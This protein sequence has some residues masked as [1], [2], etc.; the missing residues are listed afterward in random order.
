MP[1]MGESKRTKK[2][3]TLFYGRIM[4]PIMQPLPSPLALLVESV[5][6]K[7]DNFS[8]NSYTALGFF[9]FGFHRFFFVMPPWYAH[10]NQLYT[11]LWLLFPNFSNYSIEHPS[12][13]CKIDQHQ[14]IRHLH[15]HATQRNASPN[16][17]VF[18]SRPWFRYQDGGLNI[19][20]HDD[21]G[22]Y[23]APDTRHL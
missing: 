18:F 17:L 23:I 14:Q 13:C 11:K 19:A 8:F 7:I 2:T 22:R 3:T 16:Q 10:S 15:T 21:C 12:A 20:T 6:P 5:W 1:L 4:I 9:Y